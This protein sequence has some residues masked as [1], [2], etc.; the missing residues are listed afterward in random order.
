MNERKGN[1]GAKAIFEETVVK[2]F[3][4]LGKAVNTQIEEALLT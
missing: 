4:K 1:N 2:N 3:T